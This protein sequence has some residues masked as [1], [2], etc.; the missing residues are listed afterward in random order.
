M[1]KNKI[2][3]NVQIVVHKMIVLIFYANGN[4]LAFKYLYQFIRH[5]F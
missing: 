2:F 5:Q 4:L 3:R 1:L